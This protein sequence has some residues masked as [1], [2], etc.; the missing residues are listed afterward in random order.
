MAC[1]H[2]GSN[3][4]IRA[5]LI[6]E[7]FV[8]EVKVDRGEQHL[9]VHEGVTRPQ[10]S[11][12][13]HYDPDLLCARC[14]GI[15][16]RYE[17]YAVKL[18]RRLRAVRADL[19]TVVEM[20]PVDGD[21]VLRFAAGVAW[22]YAA[23]QPQF[24]RIDIGPYASVLQ[25]VAFE[26][27]PIPEALDVTVVRIVELDGDV[28]FYRAPV[29]ARHGGINSVR[30]SVGSFVIYLKIDKRP[31]D[32]I[33]PTECWLK[34]RRDGKFLIADAAYFDEGRIHRQ[35]ATGAP[36]RKFFGNMI[37]RRIERRSN[38]QR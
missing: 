31:K 26:N 14:D 35:L 15:L 12:T 8:M 20:G 23:T 2:C 36:V 29:P 18:F 4:T 6:P 33:L 24:G 25:D 21:M 16:G 9:I 27:G 37:A 38:S 17:D 19:G 10:V 28:Y 11:N 30:F 1:R 22:K 3:E 7:A 34:G 32:R 5:H 13:G